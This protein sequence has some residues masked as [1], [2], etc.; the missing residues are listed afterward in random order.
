MPNTGDE[1]P[2]S[3]SEVTLVEEAKEVSFAQEVLETAESAPKLD[4]KQLVSEEEPPAKMEDIRE[5][6]AL[7]EDSLGSES[8][9]EQLLELE[10]QISQ[11]LSQTKLDRDFNQQL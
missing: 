7:V 2:A 11:G 10:S 4:L 5:P 8:I 9:S 3:M 6:I 1:D